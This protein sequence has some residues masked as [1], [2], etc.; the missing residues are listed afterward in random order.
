MSSSSRHLPG[1]TQ[2]FTAHTRWLVWGAWPWYTGAEA[3][4]A[5]TP[6]NRQWCPPSVSLLKADYRSGGPGKMTISS[7]SVWT[8][9]FLCQPK[10]QTHAGDAL[11]SGANV[12]HTKVNFARKRISVA[13]INQPKYWHIKTNLQKVL[14]APVLHMIHQKAGYTSFRGKRLIFHTSFP[15]TF[16]FRLP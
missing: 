6:S 14:G 9:S 16:Q 2:R 12:S 7:L 15:V 5:I 8:Q 4:R 10:P 11:R 13:S 1:G 3:L